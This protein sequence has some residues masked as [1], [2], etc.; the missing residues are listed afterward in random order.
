MGQRSE[1]AGIDHRTLAALFLLAVA[2]I[3]VYRT[4]CYPGFIDLS[5]RD[6]LDYG[7]IA[8]NLAEGRGFVNTS[9]RPYQ[10]AEVPSAPAYFHHRFN[11]VFV[12]GLAL[13]FRLLG[14][15]VD[16]IIQYTSFWYFVSVPILYLLASRIFDGRIAVAA[17][18]FFAF[19]TRLL[20]A[21]IEG[22][23][24]T[25]FVF[26]LLCALYFC[27]S[28]T[29]LHHTLLAG[30]FAGSLQLI[31]PYG[32]L[33][34]PGFLIFLL[35]TTEKKARWKNV[36]AFLCAVALLY[37]IVP[38]T[39]Y[40][41]TGSFLIRTTNLF[42][43]TIAS[44]DYYYAEQVGSTADKLRAA[45]DH[46]LSAHGDTFVFGN[47][48]IIA[49]GFVSLFKR[50]DSPVR[51]GFRWF[52]FLSMASLFGVMT[53]TFYHKIYLLPLSVPF[54]ILASDTLLTYARAFREGERRYVAHPH[55][56]I[57][58]LTTLFF[59]FFPYLI[60]TSSN[61]VS[62]MSGHVTRDCLEGYG[63]FL[64]DHTR[65]DDVL[66]TSLGSVTAWMGDRTV[67]YE[68]ARLDDFWEI[69]ERVG[70]DYWIRIR[71]EGSYHS[72]RL[73][74]TLKD[75]PPDGEVPGFEIA[76]VFSNHCMQ[77]D[78]YRRKSGQSEKAN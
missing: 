12:W 70:I 62:R 57:A 40:A 18:F 77:A 28:K 31:R 29:R 73:G 15:S 20:A 34:L 30:L 39:D 69:D 47:P 53:L 56:L 26:F 1:R 13:W 68:P 61:L 43:R 44:S 72:P 19:D 63:E 67:I 41:T 5:A 42:D 52:V 64:K 35:L 8:R 59:M 50:Y 37:A 51:S 38:F 24:E 32:F 23:T 10:V 76:E 7:T 16:T 54:M 9:I 48:F 58:G 45:R 3:L 22:R 14:T 11:F 25:M 4:L 6:A 27:S 71:L 74:T 60:V 21:S 78:L 49:L 46:V 17:C 66:V 55:L 65:W 36:S 33:Y 75:V 2:T